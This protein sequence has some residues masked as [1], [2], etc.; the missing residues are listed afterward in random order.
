MDN[1]NDLS[2]VINK[3]CESLLLKDDDQT[4][5]N[6]INTLP[7]TF[8][9]IENKID[10]FLKNK[11]QDLPIFDYPVN[12]SSELR[13]DENVY[14]NE[15]VTEASTCLEGKYIKIKNEI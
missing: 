5:L 15:C 3:E 8:S 13:S 9:N 10:I 6:F 2:N 7:Q 11:S 1:K 4:F 12:F 14:N